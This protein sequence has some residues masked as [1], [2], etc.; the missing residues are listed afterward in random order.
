VVV[1][2]VEI[3]SVRAELYLVAEVVGGNGLISKSR[4]SR[5][6]GS[7]GLVLQV[8]TRFALQLSTGPAGS[9]LFSWASLGAGCLSF[10]V[11]NAA[12]ARGTRMKNMTSIPQYIA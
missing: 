6:L 2:K 7:T 8:V 12:Y 11:G 9:W 5:K 3:R 4:F 10:V 1:K